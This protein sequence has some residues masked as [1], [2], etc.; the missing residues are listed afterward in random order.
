M[1]EAANPANPNG[2]HGGDIKGISDKLDYIAGLGVT[3]IWLNPVLENNMPAYSYHGYA[4]T[5]FYRVDPRF[6]DN[7]VTEN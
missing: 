3:A 6:G 1:L 5:D 4:I 2:R 7:E